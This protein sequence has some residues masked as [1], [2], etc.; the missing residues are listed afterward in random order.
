M[1]KQPKLPPRWF[2]RGAWKAHKALLKVT[3][4]REGGSVTLE[5]V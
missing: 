4:A 3:A 2:V 1:S 5:I